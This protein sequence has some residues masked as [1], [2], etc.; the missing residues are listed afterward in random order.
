MRFIE[1]DGLGAGNRR[2]QPFSQELN[3]EI[4]IGQLPNA[5]QQRS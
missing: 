3:H 5:R 4:G 1:G 2:W